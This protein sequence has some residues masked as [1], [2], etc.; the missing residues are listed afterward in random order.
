MIDRMKLAAG[1]WLAGYKA[2][3]RAN[4]VNAAILAGAVLL[5]A[6]LVSCAI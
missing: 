3:L 6:S 2:W 5:L 4:K 1:L